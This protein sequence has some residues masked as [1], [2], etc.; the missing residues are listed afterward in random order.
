MLYGQ[1]TA[2]DDRF[3]AEDGWIDRDAFQEFV[4]VHRKALLSI[5]R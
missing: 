3:T 1:S 5:G 4:F 2:A